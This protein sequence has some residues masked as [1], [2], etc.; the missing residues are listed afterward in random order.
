MQETLDFSADLL[1]SRNSLVCR[2]Y[3]SY[4][5]C[6]RLHLHNTP[7]CVSAYPDAFQFVAPGDRRG[8]W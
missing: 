7:P 3:V 8:P 2:S 6:S 4:L 5:S 1:I